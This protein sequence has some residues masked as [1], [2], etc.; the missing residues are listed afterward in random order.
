MFSQGSSEIEEE[1]KR[2]RTK[3]YQQSLEAG[4]RGVTDSPLELS[5]GTQA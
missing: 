3:G 4:K 1:S 5:E 2:S